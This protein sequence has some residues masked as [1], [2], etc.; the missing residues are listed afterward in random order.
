MFMHLLGYPTHFGQMECLKLI[1]SSTYLEKARA[2]G[3]ALGAWRRRRVATAW[4]RHSRAAWRDTRGAQRRITRA[5]AACCRAG[6]RVRP[7]THA[8][9]LH[10]ASAT[11]A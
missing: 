6:L 8:S 2:C 4:L 7:L 10:S 3:C 1:S 5:D 9:T 11:W